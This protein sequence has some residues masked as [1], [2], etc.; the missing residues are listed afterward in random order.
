LDTASFNVLY[1]EEAIKEIDEILVSKKFYITPEGGITYSAESDT[2]DFTIKH[3]CEVPDS[4]KDTLSTENIDNLSIEGY[5]D[6]IIEEEDVPGEIRP[7]YPDEDMKEDYYF[8]CENGNVYKRINMGSKYVYKPMRPFVTKDGYV[9]YVLTTKNGRK[10]HEQ[11]QRIT[12]KAFIGKPKEKNMQVNHKNGVRNDN[13]VSNLEWVTPSENIRHSF[14]ELGKQVWNKHN[15]IYV[16]ID[17]VVM[18]PNVSSKLVRSIDDHIRDRKMK[19]ISMKSMETIPNDGVLFILIG[20]NGKYS[21]IEED[22]IMIGCCETYNDEK[23]IVLN[24]DSIPYKLCNKKYRIN[25]EDNEIEK[26]L[27]TV[28]KYD[29]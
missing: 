24:I 19:V 6:N 7:I 17:D 11:A 10:K 14:D 2:L 1:T 12:A 27:T 26:I 3:L 13:R 8:V 25:L 22:K 20:R 15:R 21:Y 16:V 28:G 5:N 4:I 23:T 18:K 9:E 29:K